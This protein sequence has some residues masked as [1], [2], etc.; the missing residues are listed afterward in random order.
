MSCEAQRQTTSWNDLSSAISDKIS[1][2]DGL[3]IVVFKE[4]K[5]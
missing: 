4:N 2:K 3:A 5:I 1:L